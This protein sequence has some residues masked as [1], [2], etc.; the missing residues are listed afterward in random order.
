MRR[1]G[2]DSQ[3]FAEKQKLL[4]AQKQ[5]RDDAGVKITRRPRSY[6]DCPAC[7]HDWREHIPPEPCSE[8]QYDIEHEEPGAPAIACTETAPPAGNR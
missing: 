2:L 1:R 8:C 4:P 3:A 5:D 7:G 6:G